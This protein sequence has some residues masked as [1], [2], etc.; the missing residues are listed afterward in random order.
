MLAPVGDKAKSSVRRRWALLL[1]ALL[2]TAAV[3]FVCSRFQVWDRLQSLSSSIHAEFVLSGLLATVCLIAVRAHRWNMIVGACGEN[4]S[5][6]ELT[7][8]YGASFFLGLVSPGK[9]GELMRIW[10]VR[11]RVGGISTATFTVAFDRI[12]DL[13]PTLILSAAFGV[14][15]GYG[16]TVNRG[17]V[18]GGAGILAV[19]SVILLCHPAW[20]WRQVDRL[21]GRL[22]KRLHARGSITS[23]DAV[24]SAAPR[25]GRG[26]IA[27]AL[28][29]S[30]FSQILALGQVYL[31]ACALGLELNPLMIY[32][33]VTVAT[34]VASL[35]LSIA[36]FGTREIAVVLAL[37]SLG[38][39][40]EDA[41]SFSLLWLGNFVAMLGL[42]FVAFL[43][44]SMNPVTSQLRNES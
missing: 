15:S 32:A 36:G 2:G 42:S 8:V 41:V 44:D 1:R 33:V 40:N 27:S 21:S 35:P 18:V 26:M 16:G 24:D 5:L 7:R 20:L 14:V 25:L 31:F 3:V 37:T 34:V 39:S 10:S 4:L 12:F 23:P 17:I 13:A 38:V 29:L 22:L 11:D 43:A 9:I 30:A 6:A 28:A 19:G